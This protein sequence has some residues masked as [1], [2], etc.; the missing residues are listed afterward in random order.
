[1]NA[2]SLHRTRIAA[3]TTAFAVLA[4]IASPLPAQAQDDPAKPAADTAI[5]DIK[6]TDDMSTEELISTLE[7]VSK[8]AEAHSEAVNKLE[9]DIKAQKKTLKA[10]Q[11]SAADTK[12]AAE[13]AR[14]A[15]NGKREAATPIYR[16]SLNNV[17]A[18]PL[19]A[20]LGATDPQQAID[21]TAYLNSINRGNTQNLKAVS[22]TTS[23]AGELHAQAAAH[24]A[25]AKFELSK[26]TI[27]ENKLK[28]ERKSLDKLI[29]TIKKRIDELEPAELAQ[30]RD[31]LGSIDPKLIK[32]DASNVLA[33]GMTKIGSPYSWGAIGPNEFDCSGLVMWSY[34]QTGKTI[35][36]TAAA[37]V[38]GGTPVSR[39]DLQPG[40][41]VGF[42]SPVSH[43][44]IYAGDGMVLHASDYGIPVQVAPLDS[45]PFTGASRY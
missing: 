37:Q 19:T 11:K 24:E 28:D 35:P 10:T 42:Y 16:A 18:D 30:W 12:K 27:Q 23:K 1:M 6:L 45:M 29:D 40:D 5:S 44:G 31:R 2:R 33:A 41:V 22:E 38:A 26:L 25:T 34:Q 7:K 4:A 32:A 13:E 3:A 15:A 8:K 17:Q 36:R 9:V 43:V 14:E 39:A 20:V 21:R